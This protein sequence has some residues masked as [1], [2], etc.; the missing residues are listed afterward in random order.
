MRKRCWFILLFV[1]VSSFFIALHFD[2]P[3]L[4]ETYTHIAKKGDTLWSICEKYY[5]DPELW[6]KLW[7]INPFVTNPH[8]LK[9]GDTIKLLE[10]VPCDVLPEVLSGILPYHTREKMHRSKARVMKK[11]TSFNTLSKD[12][13][14]PMVP[15][16]PVESLVSTKN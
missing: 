2:T 5:G 6:P 14:S 3:A 10:D 15:S 16:A 8:L 9:P 11:S 1:A 4:A 7:Q 12:E 13:N